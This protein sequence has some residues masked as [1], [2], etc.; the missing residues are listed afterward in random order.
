MAKFARLPHLFEGKRRKCTLT[1]YRPLKSTA[2]EK[3]MKLVIASSLT[4]QPFDGMPEEFAEEFAVMNKEKSLTNFKKV[5]VEMEGTLFSVFATDT[6]GIYWKSHAVVINSF[7]LIGA[8]VED[9]RTVDLEFT[10][11]VPW[12]EA[13]RKWLD[14][15]LHEDFYL[16]VIPSQQELKAEKPAEKPVGKKKK[17]GKSLEFDPEALQRAAK[18]GEYEGAVN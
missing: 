9:K 4:D 14:E 17:G 7:K 11:Y 8:G 5:N 13:L 6:S 16:E 3:R 1:D 10:A 15:T 2:K 12:S 18:D